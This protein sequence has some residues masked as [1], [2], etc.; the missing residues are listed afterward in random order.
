MKK[1]SMDLC[2]CYVSYLAFKTCRI[3][4]CT[5]TKYDSYTNV[6][7]WAKLQWFLEKKQAIKSGMCFLLWKIFFSG[8]V[9]GQE[10]TQKLFVINYV[11]V[12]IVHSIHVHMYI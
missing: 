5:N 6:L 2:Y 9:S 10:K 7:I 12:H 4:D 8:N 3:Q 1:N 11:S